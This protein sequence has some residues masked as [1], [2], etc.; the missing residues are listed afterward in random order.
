MSAGSLHIFDKRPKICVPVLRNALAGE[1]NGLNLLC[2]ICAYV[3]L[4][5]LASF[6]VHTEATIKRG[7]RVAKKF[8]EL[9]NVSSP[10]YYRTNV[11]VTDYLKLIGVSKGCVELPQDAPDPTPVR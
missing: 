9:A 1:T 6:E 5:L 11:V 8:S 7:R 10:S 2:A 4:D 3:E